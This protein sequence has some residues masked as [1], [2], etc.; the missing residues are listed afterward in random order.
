M[1]RLLLLSLVFGLFSS[2]DADKNQST[3]VS[4]QEMK[5]L[6]V[7]DSVQLI[8]VRT[9]E[10]FREG[11]L[12]GAQN[13]VYDNEFAY[14]IKQLDKS[15]PVAVYCRSGRRSQE[16]SQILKQAGFKK[17]YQLRGGLSQWEYED[18]IV[19]DSLTP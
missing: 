16:C 17:I 3:L 6:M 2:C 7:M 14:K 15:K 9:L 11:H 18:L 5:E 12:I 19:S 8:D 10:E 13:L 4:P 1:R